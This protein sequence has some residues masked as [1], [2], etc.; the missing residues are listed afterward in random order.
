MER[1]VLEKQEG[2]LGH[3]EGMGCGSA[4]AVGWLGRAV[5]VL[6]QQER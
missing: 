5:G 6:G 4:S 2:I 3:W 1:E